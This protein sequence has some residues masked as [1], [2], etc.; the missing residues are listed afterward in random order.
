MLTQASL[1][2]PKN[3]EGKNVDWCDVWIDSPDEAQFA[4]RRTKKTPFKEIALN[5]LEYAKKDIGESEIFSAVRDVFQLFL[6]DY[7]LKLN[8]DDLI[9]LIGMLLTPFSIPTNRIKSIWVSVKKQQFSKALRVKTFP[10]NSDNNCYAVKTYASMEAITHEVNELK[11]IHSKA[12]FITNAA[13][14]TGKTQTLMMPQFKDEERAGHHPIIITPTQA[15]TKNVAEKFQTAHYQK[16]R[17]CLTDKKGL[18]ITINSIIQEPFELFLQKSQ[19]IF[20]DEYTQ[21]LRSITSGTVK[22]SH[23]QKTHQALSDLIKK[24]Q[25]VYI[26]DADLN[27]IAL[28]DLIQSRE[29]GT[30]IFVMTLEKVEQKTPY[31]LY[32]CSPN[33]GKITTLHL[34]SEALDKKEPC[35]VVADSR[36]KIAVL[37]EYLK[38]EGINPLIISSESIKT[39]SVQEFLHQPDNFL[40]KEKPEVVIVSP[41]IQSGLSIESDYFKRILGIYTGTVSPAVLSQMLNRVRKP[42]LREVIITENR[43]K[44]FGNENSDA[45]LSESYSHYMQQFGAQHTYFDKQTGVTH[46]GHLSLKQT[47]KGLLI[48]GD[49]LFERFERLSAELKA[50]ENQQKNQSSAFF[51]LQLMAEGVPMEIKNAVIDE[52][53]KALLSFKEAK[54]ENTAIEERYNA[55]CGES[56]LSKAHYKQ[57]KTAEVNTLEEVH[58]MQQFE[59]AETLQI[60]EIKPSDVDFFDNDGKKI[61]ENYQDLKNRLESAQRKD[62]IE[63]QQAIS[64]Q[65]LSMCTAKVQLLTVLFSILGLD[66]DTGTGCYSNKKALKV[67]NIIRQDASLSRYVL[68]KLSLSVNSSL[69]DVAFINKILKKLLG[70]K[71]ER[72]LLREGIERTWIYTVK[73]AFEPLIKYANKGQ[74]ETNEKNCHQK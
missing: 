19:S 54:A 48:Q 2:Y 24:S 28:N 38:E 8:E 9:T 60:K 49:P 56:T 70:L 59:I 69:S 17:D 65:D 4:F 21:I 29:E 37:T 41:A 53:I 26:A 57:L 36:K 74:Y 51:A 20:I 58:A 15:L 22:P 30:P 3:E 32:P 44:T 72:F 10:I 31:T 71:A 27:T 14:G 42:V 25:Y 45:L 35:Y 68:L 16:E 73:F 34:L 46:M 52:K 11:K 40:M 67:R 23:R 6:S 5:R 12:I 47:D 33:Q 61:L 55:V 7:P 43:G 63:Q 39:P 62:E 13:M 66:I 18:A 50:L 1:L 64:K